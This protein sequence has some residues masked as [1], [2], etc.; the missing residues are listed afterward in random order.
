MR[1]VRSRLLSASKLVP[2]VATTIWTMASLAVFSASAAAL[3]TAASLKTRTARAI[4]PSSSPRPL[5]GTLISL[6]PVASSPIVA[7]K[8]AMGLAINLLSIT[9]RATAIPM[10]AAPPT[11]SAVVALAIASSCRAEL[12]LMRST[13][14]LRISRNGNTAAEVST[15]FPAPRTSSC[16]ASRAPAETRSIR[17]SPHFS[18]HSNVAWRD[19]NRATFC[20]GSVN[21]RSS[22]TDM[23]S[24]SSCASL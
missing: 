17:R 6:L 20:A 10:S 18:R 14:A 15:A 11:T 24:Y 4:A 12:R 9:A 19:R 23:L 21:S 13:C 7:V 1:V 8:R 22:L 2:S 5:S 16:A 3:A